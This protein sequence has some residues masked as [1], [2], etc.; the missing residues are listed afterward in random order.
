MLGN[1][2]WYANRNGVRNLLRNAAGLTYGLHLGN[3]SGRRVR[4]LTSASFANPSCVANR[5]LSS[6]CFAN[7][8]SVADRNLLGAVFANHSSYAVVFNSLLLLAYPASGAVVDSACLWFANESRGAVV[9][10]FRLWLEY[11]LGNGARDLLRYWLAY[12]AANGVRNLLA[13]GFAAVLGDRNLL[14]FARRNPYLTADRAIRTLAA[15]LFAAARCVA[16]ATG[17]WISCP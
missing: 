12:S 8:T 15:D 11:V 7:P 6:F 4:D 3:L 2:S 1:T 9:D 14:G 16:T 5:N 10:Y 17:A 13:N